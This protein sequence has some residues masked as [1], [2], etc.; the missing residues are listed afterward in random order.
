MSDEIIKILN[1]LAEKFGTMVDW[2]QQNLSL[3]HI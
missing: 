1:A 3:I 2:S